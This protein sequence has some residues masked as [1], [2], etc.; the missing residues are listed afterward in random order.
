MTD[1]NSTLCRLLGERIRT[2]REELK[3][4]QVELSEKAGLGRSS[5]SNIE[6]GRQSPPL[7]VLYQ[8]CSALNID[9]HLVLPT[10]M[11]VQAII[12]KGPDDQIEKY[13]NTLDLDKN[14]LDKI[15]SIIKKADDNAK[16]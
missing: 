11:E 14:A 8:I 12:S 1:F 9:I 7:A 2:R 4:S 10:N 6:K 15:R 5:I 16:L 13:F 3:L